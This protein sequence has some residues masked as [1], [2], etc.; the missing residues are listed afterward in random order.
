MDLENEG[1]SSNEVGKI[2]SLVRIELSNQQKEGFLNHATINLPFIL[3]LL[4]KTSCVKRLPYTEYRKNLCYFCLQKI[5]PTFISLTS[6][7]NQFSEFRIFCLFTLILLTSSNNQ[8]YEFRI[9][10]I[11]NEILLIL[12]FA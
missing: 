11:Y 12:F 2:C 10:N 6:S 7:N 1:M 5:F 3:G 8:I 4:Q 9:P